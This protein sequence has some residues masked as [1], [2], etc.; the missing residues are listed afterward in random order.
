MNE[1]RMLGLLGGMSWE[2]SLV[3]YRLIN[4]GVNQARGGLHSAPM[5]LASVD[6]AEVAALMHAGDWPTV[7]EHLGAAAAGL[8]RGGAQALLIATNTMHKVAATVQVRAGLPLL[9]IGDA[10][11][12]ALRAAGR[13]RTGLLGTRFTMEDPFLREHLGRHWDVDCVVPDEADRREV[14]RIIF[15]ELCQ[16]RCLPASR[17]RLLAVIERLGAQNVDSVVLGCTELSLLLDPA[18]DGE[19]LP[20]FDTTALHAAAAVHWLLEE[21]PCP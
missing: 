4:Q 14:H 18:N 2:S 13:R 12:Q 11:G 16:G 1:R 20:L 6:F 3:Y 10:T 8:Q 17:L 19:A 9:H 5:L 15:D 7:A 21:T